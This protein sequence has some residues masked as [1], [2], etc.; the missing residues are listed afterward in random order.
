MGPRLREH[1]WPDDSCKSGM[2]HSLANPCTYI[3]GLFEISSNNLSQIITKISSYPDCCDDE[4]GSHDA[5]VGFVDHGRG[6]D[7]VAAVGGVEDEVD[8]EDDEGGD[9]EDEPGEEARVGRPAVGVEDQGVVAVL[10]T[11]NITSCS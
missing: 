8:D 4:D 9:E 10:G 7:V 1:A 6:L 3:P 5:L 11:L 2:Y